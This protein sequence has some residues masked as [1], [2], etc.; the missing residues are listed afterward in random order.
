MTEYE[1]YNR[2]LDENI[3]MY[4][5]LI[6]AATKKMEAQ[7]AEVKIRIER[8]HDTVHEAELHKALV[9]RAEKAIIPIQSALNFTAANQALQGNLIFA[10]NQAASPAAAQ[11]AAQIIN[12]Y[13]NEE[14]QDVVLFSEEELKKIADEESRQNAETIQ[15]QENRKKAVQ[16]AQ[17][18][19]E[20][21]KQTGVFKGLIDTLK[22][23]Y[24]NVSEKLAS[25]RDARE[26]NKKQQQQTAKQEEEYKT[27]RE[28]KNA[29]SLLSIV[30]EQA[31]ATINN[32]SILKNE[33]IATEL[34]KTLIETQQQSEH[35]KA[36]RGGMGGRRTTRRARRARHSSLPAA[37]LP[38]ARSR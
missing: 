13:P 22:G 2:L 1:T 20:A 33:R 35:G 21:S 30:S 4:R 15:K 17:A 11:A 26:E 28:G 31:D 3:R 16:A 23:A 36:D 24:E 32:S 14:L 38:R 29:A 5:Q 27:R 25:V 18:A 34:V 8:I 19:K 12:P 7:S 6:A 37:R 9:D 10:P